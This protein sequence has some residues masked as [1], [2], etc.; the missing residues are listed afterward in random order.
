MVND[1][2]YQGDSLKPLRM[3]KPTE[4]DSRETEKSESDFKKLTKNPASG[5]YK[6]IVSSMFWMLIKRQALQFEW[7]QI[8][9]ATSRETAAES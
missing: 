8:A 9:I 2:A 3:L 6:P 5:E 4:F 7:A 1:T